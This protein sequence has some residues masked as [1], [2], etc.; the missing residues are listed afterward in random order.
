MSN[1]PFFFLRNCEANLKGTFPSSLCKDE[2]ISADVLPGSNHQSSHH[3]LFLQ[4]WMLCLSCKHFSP[5]D[6]LLFLV[7]HLHLFGF[8]W[9]I[10]SICLPA[11]WLFMI[12]HCTSRLLMSLVADSFEF[13]LLPVSL[14]QSTEDNTKDDCQHLKLPVVAFS[15]LNKWM[16]Q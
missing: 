1:F 6:F 4:Q 16:N 14:M 9:F 5:A 12:F 8:V 7:F 2:N 15:N 10:W 11:D 13:I 3:L